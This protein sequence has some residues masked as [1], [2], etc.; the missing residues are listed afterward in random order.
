MPQFEPGEPVFR[1][2][3]YGRY[4]ECNPHNRTGYVLRIVGGGFCA[5][6]MLLMILR[7]GPFA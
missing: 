7:V 4:G 2:S 5:V 6:M 3:G 1:K